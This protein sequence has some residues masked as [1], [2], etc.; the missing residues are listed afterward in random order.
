VARLESHLSSGPSRAWMA[1]RSRTAMAFADAKEG[2]GRM[3]R[4]LGEK[5]RIGWGT[6]SERVASM[7]ETDETEDNEQPVGSD[8][9]NQGEGR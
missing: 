1:A 6:L 5:I 3:T 7:L 8:D 4:G 9:R 2:A